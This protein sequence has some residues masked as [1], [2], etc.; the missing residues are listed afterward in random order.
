MRLRSLRDNDPRAAGE[1]LRGAN[2]LPTGDPSCAMPAVCLR[3]ASSPTPMMPEQKGGMTMWAFLIF[4]AI[5]TARP[6]G[7]PT[8]PTGSH[9]DQASKACVENV[10]D[11]HLSRGELSPATEPQGGEC[12]FEKD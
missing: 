12:P 4:L 8:C 9:F 5:A 1:R 2:A 7:L 11:R 6:A 3:E 10:D